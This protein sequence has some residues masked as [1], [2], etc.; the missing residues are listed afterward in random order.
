MKVEDVAAFH[1]MASQYS[2]LSSFRVMPGLPDMLQTAHVMALIT[3]EYTEL[4]SALL[5]ENDVPNAA[6]EYIDLI[7]VAVQGLLAMG[8]Q[9][10][11]VDR[12]WSAVH[13]SNMTKVD[14]TLGKLA[15]N[16]GRPYLD[17]SG[18]ISKPPG[19]VPPDMDALVREFTA[20]RP[21]LELNL[22]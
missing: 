19:Y 22:D 7:Y 15:G 13:Q 16:D 17:T 1:R 9:P 3:E 12:L 4:T 11:E 2:G 10:S 8:F 18:K 21:E 5:I 20:T 14:P 6:K